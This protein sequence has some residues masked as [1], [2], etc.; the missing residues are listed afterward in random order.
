MTTAFDNP[1]LNETPDAIVIT[2]PDDEAVDWNKRAETD[3]GYRS[4]EP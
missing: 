4:A 2:T 1:L 3:F